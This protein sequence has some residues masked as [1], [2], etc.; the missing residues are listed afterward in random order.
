MTTILKP[1][2][3]KFMHKI[4]QQKV[5]Y[6]FTLFISDQE[7]KKHAISPSPTHKVICLNYDIK[8]KIWMLGK[9]FMEEFLRLYR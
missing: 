1:V 6:P 7:F 8:I 2:R 3:V 5:I 9:C 4:Q